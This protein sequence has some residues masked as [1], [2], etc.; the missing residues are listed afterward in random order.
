MYPW[1][2]WSSCVASLLNS[3]IFLQSFNRSVSEYTHWISHTKTISSVSKNPSFQHLV[4]HILHYSKV[5]ISNHLLSFRFQTQHTYLRHLILS[6]HRQRREAE[7]FLL[8]D[9]KQ[10]VGIIKSDLFVEQCLFWWSAGCLIRD[11]V[12]PISRTAPCMQRP[13]NNSCSKA[14]RRKCWPIMLENDSWQSSQNKTHLTGVES[15]KMT[16]DIHHNL[17]TLQKYHALI[18]LAMYCSMFSDNKKIWA[19]ESLTEDISFR[20]ELFWDYHI[21]ARHIQSSCPFNS[22]ES[23]FQMQL[24]KD[25]K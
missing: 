20:N 12:M 24:P 11:R 19:G 3:F 13:P 18:R 10:F 2:T 7:M 6:W 22:R 4:H 14:I 17:F 21:K 23:R 9:R 15:G 5:I 1:A 25:Q 8:G 16:I